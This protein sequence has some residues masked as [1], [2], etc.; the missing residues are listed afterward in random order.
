MTFPQLAAIAVAVLGCVTD[1]RTRRVPN[2]LT[3]GA[4]AGAF[5]YFLAGE[6]WAGLG[7]SAAGWGVGLLM[8]LP[9]FALRGIGGGDVK[10]LAA[11]GAW[12]GPGPAV[13]L[14]LF[15]ALA[16]GPLALVVA[17]SKGYVGQ[18][19]ANVWGLLT[20]WRV[21]GVR[22]HPALTLDN[23]TAPRLP[24]ALPIAV[25]LMVTLWL[26]Y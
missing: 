23:A 21:A 1:L 15:T 8:F 10:L 19:F 7:Q 12:I 18:A 5:G 26:R 6:G 14:A 20:F 2:V 9:L 17:A 11:L 16:G 24:Y 4:A 25:G 13:W 3:F 22:P